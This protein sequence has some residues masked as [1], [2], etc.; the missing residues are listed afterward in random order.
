MKIFISGISGLLG[1]NFAFHAKGSYEIYGGFFSNSIQIPGIQVFKVDATDPLQV[2]E[3]LSHIKPDIVV[4]L[5]ALTNVDRCESDPT[6]AKLL[7]V[8]AAEHLARYAAHVGI[9]MVHISTDHIFDGSSPMRIEADSPRPINNYAATKLK[10]ELVVQ[11]LC[12]DSL[13]V[14]TN[15]YGWGTSIRPSFTDWIISNVKTGNKLNMFSD[16]FFTPILIDQLI[17]YILDLIVK[18]VSG[19]Y[20]IVGR[21]RL[22]KYEFAL[23]LADVFGYSTDVINPVSVDEFNFHAPRPRDMSLD[24]SK[25]EALLGTKMPSAAQGLNLLR[26]LGARGKADQL[27]SALL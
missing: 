27:E 16:V 11:E 9:P 22:S 19:V 8:E 13:I 18:N 26:I 23:Q 25:L 12:P 3:I 20:N 15:F 24:G 21:E 6:L 4:N 2:D 14:R 17:D 5:V 1:L 7:N 10:G